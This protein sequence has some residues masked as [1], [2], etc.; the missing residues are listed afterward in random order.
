MLS[1]FISVSQRKSISG[2]NTP[3]SKVFYSRLCNHDFIFFYG[4]LP[5]LG[6]H[7]RF[8]QLIPLCPVRPYQRRVQCVIRFRSHRP[9][10]HSLDTD[11]PDM[12]IFFTDFFLFLR[13]P[14]INKCIIV[15]SV[16][17]DI[18]DLLHFKI[19]TSHC[20]NTKQHE[21]RQHNCRS[22]DQVLPPVAF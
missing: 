13:K 10:C 4:I 17:P 21:G 3:K 5:F 15:R 14:S 2:V 1:L 22:H 12:W 20:Q 11:H 8:R 19:S 9:S 6:N 7:S 18:L 16:H